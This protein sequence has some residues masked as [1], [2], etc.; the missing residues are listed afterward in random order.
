[1]RVFFFVCLLEVRAQ[2]NT[3]TR[4][5]C[6]VENAEITKFN[7]KTSVEAENQFDECVRGSE[8]TYLYN[9]CDDVKSVYAPF[10]L[11][12]EMAFKDKLRTLANCNY[13]VSNQVQYII[14]IIYNKCY[15]Q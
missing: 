13:Q 9:R 11:D 14:Y 4:A 8:R 6:L 3:L 10:G 15:I 2:G 7:T 12:H 5:Q 1:M